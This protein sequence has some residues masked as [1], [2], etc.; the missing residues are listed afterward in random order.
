MHRAP[1]FTEG[2]SVTRADANLFSVDVYTGQLRVGKS[3]TLDF[4]APGSADNYNDYQVTMVA[5]EIAPYDRDNWRHWND[6]DADCQD[7]RH[8]VLI[9]ESLVNVTYETVGE[10]WV[11]TRQWVGAF[12]GTTVT[13]PSD[14]DID[15]FVPLANAWKSGAWAWDED[16]KEAPITWTTRTI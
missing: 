7:T 1:A 5:S 9:A 13:D 6:A 14:L 12:T 2:S 11:E 3:A 16:K 4:E 10:C 8:E 15:H